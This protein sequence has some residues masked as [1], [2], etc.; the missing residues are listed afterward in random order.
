MAVTITRTAWIDDDGTGTT[1]TVINNAEKTALY[2]QIDAALAQLLPLAGG[3]LSGALTINS[4]LSLAGSWSAVATVNGGM[5][6][7][8]RNQ[9]TG[10]TAQ[11]SIFIGN[12]ADQNLFQINV[13]SSTNSA[14]GASGFYANGAALYHSGAGPLT[15]HAANASGRIEIWTAAGR[16]WWFDNAGSLLGGAGGGVGNQ[17][18]NLASG[19]VTFGNAGTGAANVASFWNANGNIGSISTSGTATAYNTASDARLKRDRGVVQTTDRLARLVVHDFEWL[20]DGAPGRG[21]FA[22]EAIAVVPDAVAEGNDDGR[23]WQ[24][25]YSKFVPE[26]IVGW[27][28][29]AAELAA[30]RAELA[31]LK[32]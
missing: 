7:V 22:Q 25:D 2:N 3:T 32:G 11:T 15:L 8:L 17:F 4:T 31:A 19:I 13:F 29:H 10:A 26:L 9:S 24:T 21:V 6:C 18:T 16:R 27:Q 14:A 12:D 28:Q 5:I 1:G 30:L 23:P 20:V